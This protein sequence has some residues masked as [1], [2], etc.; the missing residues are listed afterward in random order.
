MKAWWA[1]AS[2]VILSAPFF[3]SGCLKVKV[4]SGAEAQGDGAIAGNPTGALSGAW[5]SNVQFQDGSFAAIKDL[6]F[7]YVFNQGGTLTE[8]SNYD[9]APPVPPAY[10]IWRSAGENQFEATYSYFN[11]KAPARLED[12]SSGSGWLPAGRGVLTERV[13]LAEDGQSFQSEIALQLYDS[14]G[15]PI[16]GG[17]RGTGRAT[18]MHF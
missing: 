9:G 3:G 16:E 14:S 18:R 8:S 13:T 1:I 5:R 17:G 11:S 10:G 6:E 15:N 4:N 12:L 7:L 2:V